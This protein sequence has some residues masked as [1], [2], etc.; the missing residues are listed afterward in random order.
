M[1]RHSGGVP[2]SSAWS[3]RVDTVNTNDETRESF[4]ARIVGRVA[5]T[6]RLNVM[7]SPLEIFHVIVNGGVPRPSSGGFPWHV[8]R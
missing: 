7:A 1:H 2:H 3:S 8:V 4:H 6:G 5:H